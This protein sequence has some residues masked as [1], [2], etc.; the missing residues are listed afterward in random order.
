MGRYLWVVIA[1]VAVAI[2][3]F[4]VIEKRLQNEVSKNQKLKELYYEKQLEAQRAR[5][6]NRQLRD[7]I[8]QERG[9]LVKKYD[10][11]K[12]MDSIVIAYYKKRVKGISNTTPDELQKQ[13]LEYYLLH[14]RDS[15]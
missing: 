9:K 14:A 7:S 11:L 10:S 3:V 5:F 8:R 13:M 6:E 2:G 4:T 15:M 12:S 1:I